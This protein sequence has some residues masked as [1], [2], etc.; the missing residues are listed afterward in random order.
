MD[1]CEIKCEEALPEFSLHSKI[2]ELRYLDD[3][4]PD[5]KFSMAMLTKTMHLP[6]V[7]L[8]AAADR[9]LRYLKTTID[10]RLVFCPEDLQLR[11]YCDASYA[12]HADGRSHFGT[13]LRL[14]ITTAAFHVRSSSIKPVVRSSTEAE[15]FAINDLA[16]DALHAYDLLNEIG[17]TQ[18]P[19]EIFEDNE[20][21]ITMAY[22]PDFNFQTK[23]KHVRVRI[24]FVKQQVTEGIFHILHVISALQQT[25]CLTKPTVGVGFNNGGDWLMGSLST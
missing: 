15:I 22:A 24:A 10:K 16:S 12:I 18:G 20:A 11:G 25:D 7:A 14:G 6:S 21:V 19:I 2:M 8:E 4:R 17:F 1:I 3:A 5:I 9:V 23:S 13:L